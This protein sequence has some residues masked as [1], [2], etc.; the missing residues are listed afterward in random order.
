VDVVGT[1]EEAGLKRVPGS[2]QP[3]KL[4]LR[5]LASTRSRS[6]CKYANV[7]AVLG[8]A[9]VGAAVLTAVLTAVLLVTSVVA[10]VVP[11]AL[12]TAVMACALVGLWFVLPLTRRVDS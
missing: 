2:V 12:I 4:L 9:A 8:L 5:A 7:M 3:K 10:G 6:P 11:A 1:R